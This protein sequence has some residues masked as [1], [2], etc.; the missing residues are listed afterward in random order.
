MTFAKKRQL[1]TIS[2]RRMIR[3]DEKSDFEQLESVTVAENR[4]F[5][6]VSLK[7]QIIR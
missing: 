6:V 4:V 7:R 3:Y 1:H 5:G 2:E